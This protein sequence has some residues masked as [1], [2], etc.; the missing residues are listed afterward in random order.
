SAHTHALANKTS[1]HPTMR[2]FFCTKLYISKYIAK[3]T[4]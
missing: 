1:K 3:F 2:V 4:G